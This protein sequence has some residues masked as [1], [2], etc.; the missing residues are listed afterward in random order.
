V[1]AVELA[2]FFSG[3]PSLVRAAIVG[4]LAYVAL[5]LFLRISGKRTL[6]KL[7]AFDLV[8]TVSLGSTLA[9]ILLN[10]EVA[11]AE[12]VLAFAVLIG[13]QYSVAWLSVRSPF[14]RKTSQERAEA[15]VASRRISGGCA[16]D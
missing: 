4:V 15:V 11:L 8:V 5:V 14:I 13:L 6:S 9:T 3:W 7:S 1:Q 12:G 10:K 16:D 2:I